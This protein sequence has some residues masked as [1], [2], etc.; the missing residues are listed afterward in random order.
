M[1]YLNQ[2][3]SEKRKFIIEKI[4]QIEN[5]AIL[6]EMVSFLELRD[7]QD[8]ERR[9]ANGHTSEKFLEKIKV[10]INKYSWK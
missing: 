2:I 9:F 7:E 4:Q 1:V 10:K 5:E 6:D 8:F 3:V